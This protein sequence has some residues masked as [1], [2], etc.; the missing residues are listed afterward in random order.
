M[1]GESNE[2]FVSF[3]LNFFFPFSSVCGDGCHQKCK[4]WLQKDK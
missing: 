3:W 2:L 1:N 4:E